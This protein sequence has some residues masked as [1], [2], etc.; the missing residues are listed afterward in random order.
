MHG[1]GRLKSEKLSQLVK[2]C[3]YLAACQ[4]DLCVHAFQLTVGFSEAAS[5]YCVP[6][7]Y[8]RSDWGR[9]RRRKQAQA[10]ILWKMEHLALSAV[11]SH[12]FM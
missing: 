6:I 12:G 7:M 10:Q 5:I 4:G 8:V 1:G 11:Y 2:L 3:N 9:K